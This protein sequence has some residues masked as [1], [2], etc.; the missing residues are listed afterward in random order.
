[1]KRT[2]VRAGV[3]ERPTLFRWIA[4][5]LLLE[6]RPQAELSALSSRRSTTRLS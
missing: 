1:M 4:P 2:G 6:G 5:Q 3:E